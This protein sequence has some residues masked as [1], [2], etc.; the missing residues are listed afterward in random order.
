MQPPF[1]GDK[2]LSILRGEDN[3]ARKGEPAVKREHPQKR[4]VRCGKPTSRRRA[5]RPTCLYCRVV[6]TEL[7]ADKELRKMG[8]LKG[9]H[10][11]I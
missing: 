9:T 8:K 11:R 2:I 7:A 5:G 1:P 6:L 10:G 4:C 3:S